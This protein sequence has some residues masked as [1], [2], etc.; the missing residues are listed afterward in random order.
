MFEPTDCFLSSDESELLS[1]LEE[2]ESESGK[3]ESDESEL[4]ESKSEESES[5]ESDEA[6]SLNFCKR[7]VFI[8]RT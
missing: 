6:N 2:I 8:L 5:D 3:S 4:D 7:S 1:S